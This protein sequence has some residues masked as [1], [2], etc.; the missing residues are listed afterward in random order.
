MSAAV[1]AGCLL[2]TSFWPTRKLHPVLLHITF[3]L[4]EA[5][6]CLV[7]SKTACLA[8]MVGGKKN[9]STATLTCKT[10]LK[11]INKIFNVLPSRKPKMCRSAKPAWIIMCAFT[12]MLGLSPNR[13]AWFCSTVAREEEAWPEPSD[14]GTQTRVKNGTLT[15]MSTT[16]SSLFKSGEN[17]G[18][19]LLNASCRSLTSHPE[20]ASSPS[21]HSLWTLPLIF[22]HAS[23]T[24]KNPLPEVLGLAGW[25]LE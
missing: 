11:Q 13:G 14:V 9:K 22:C 2:I 21:G 18:D 5:L 3:T 12:E 15:L 16:G 7:I 1:V 4:S 19:W 24:N 25:K 8:L 20:A 6:K 17:Q 10:H 23:G